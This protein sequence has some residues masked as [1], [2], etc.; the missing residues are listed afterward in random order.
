DTQPMRMYLRSGGRL[1]RDAPGKDENASSF[2][3]DRDARSGKRSRWRTLVSPFVVPDYRDAG[4]RAMSFTSDPLESNVEM[5]GHA[6]ATLSLRSDVPDGAV[7]VYLEELTA[8]GRTVYVTEGQLRLVHHAV[9][10]RAPAAYRSPIPHRSF[11]RGASRPFP[12]DR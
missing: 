3:V 6:L 8:D 4:R 11:E 10:D 2:D 12:T 5:T 9:D 1:R 7:F